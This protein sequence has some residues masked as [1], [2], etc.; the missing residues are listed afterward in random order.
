MVRKI[1]S[2][3]ILAM[4]CN[5]S[6]L[7][8]TG[9][10][11]EVEVNRTF[12]YVEVFTKAYKNGEYGIR[13]CGERGAKTFYERANET[14]GGYANNCKAWLSMAEISV[15]TGLPLKIELNTPLN[16]CLGDGNYR[17]T[18]VYS[19]SLVR[20]DSLNDE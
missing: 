17:D 14:N 13:I 8:C 2:L 9:V 11:D 10:I 20:K 19:V 15:A 3:S 16:D 12:S 18:F 5:A 4:S 1:V 7:T 6:A